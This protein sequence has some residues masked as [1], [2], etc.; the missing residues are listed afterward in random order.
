MHPYISM[1]VLHTV[2]YT[3]PKGA[4][5]ENLLYNQNLFLLVIILSI[6]VT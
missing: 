1:H 4:G 5:K 2:L 3:F 6:L